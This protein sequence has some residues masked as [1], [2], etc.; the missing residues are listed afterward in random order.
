MANDLKR[1]LDDLENPPLKKLQPLSE[2]NY[3]I[4][5]VLRLLNKIPKLQQMTAI[6]VLIEVWYKIIEENPTVETFYPCEYK[7]YVLNA[8]SKL[9]LS[10]SLVEYL[11]FYSDS[12]INS[13]NGWMRHVR[14]HCNFKSDPP[15]VVRN[16]LYCVVWTPRGGI[17]YVNTAMLLL[18]QDDVSVNMKFLI[19]C[20][21]CL[22]DYVE[23][24]KAMVY[25][26]LLNESRDEYWLAYYW[27]VNTSS[28]NGRCKRLVADLLT[29]SSGSAD[30][31]KYFW[32]KLT[33]PDKKEC[34][35]SWLYREMPS[36]VSSFGPVTFFLQRLHD[37]ELE[38]LLA[39]FTSDKFVCNIF[40]TRI[41]EI[42]SSLNKEK[43]WNESFDEILISVRNIVSHISYDHPL[44]S[45]WNL[46]KMLHS[47]WYHL[48]MQYEC[49][50]IPLG[51]NFIMVLNS[52]WTLI[53]EDDRK[54]DLE[55]P[56]V[57]HSVEWSIDTYIALFNEMSKQLRKKLM[58]CNEC[59]KRITSFV[60]K[61]EFSRL[62][63]FIEEKFSPDE[64]TDL[65]KLILLELLFGTVQWKDV[66]LAIKKINPVT[67]SVDDFCE[68]SDVVMRFYKKGVDDLHKIRSRLVILYSEEIQKKMDDYE[69]R[70]AELTRALEWCFV[71]TK[72]KKRRL[73]KIPMNKKIRVILY[74]EFESKNDA[75]SLDCL[76]K[77]VISE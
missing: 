67:Q 21:Y 2:V 74:K 28:S 10:S 41:F 9:S 76:K 25:S 12:V 38:E 5:R 1:K 56:S 35:K 58:S 47:M 53:S 69:A 57:T 70:C 60:F 20:T 24:Y 30:C 4:R 66:E 62:K 33:M 43:Y 26:K 77:F 64:A 50:V 61:D 49:N 6:S 54:N 45:T 42:L 19:A 3:E 14:V 29:R 36:D 68:L 65:L 48:E 15:F 75:V 55:F 46:R 22:D 63:N 59:I 71:W 13:L 11:L 8:I 39:Q 7:S 16:F 37:G 17:D 73:S 18:H 40:I 23:L 52:L 34:I 31:L 51:K 32:N 44:F 72:S 27:A